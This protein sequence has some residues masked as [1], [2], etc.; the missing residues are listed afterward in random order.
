VDASPADEEASHEHLAPYETPIHYFRAFRFHP[1]F[2]ETVPG[3]IRSLTYSHKINVQQPM[4]PDQVAGHQCPRGQ[5]CEFQHF[6]SMQ[7]S[8]PEIITALMEYGRF[9]T[10]EQERYIQGLREVLADLRNRNVKDLDAISRGIIEFRA[11]F[12]Q[13]QSRVLP[14]G[15]ISL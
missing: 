3:G 1:L 9:E 13:D 11:R 6:E 10:G 12:L 7:V 5:A 8:D 15:S 14:L 4:C 2:R